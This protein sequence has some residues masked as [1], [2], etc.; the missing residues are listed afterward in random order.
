VD[1]GERR[2]LAFVI[3][4][5]SLAATRQPQAHLI[6]VLFLYCFH[7]YGIDMDQ[8]KRFFNPDRVA[9]LRALNRGDRLK[10]TASVRI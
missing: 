8:R 4:D 6:V 7:G 2:V 3:G 5:V 1:T 10:T 9:A